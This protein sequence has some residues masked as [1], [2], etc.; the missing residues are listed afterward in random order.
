[1]DADSKNH[2]LSGRKMLTELLQWL[3]Q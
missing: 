1:M 2:H 3:P